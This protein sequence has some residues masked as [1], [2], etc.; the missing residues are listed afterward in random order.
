M[1]QQLV[2]AGVE[3]VAVAFVNAYKN[4]THERRVAELV[5]AQAPGVA[6][7]PSSEVA[8]V[9][10]EYE[11]TS[12]V[13]ADA[14]VLPLADGYLVGMAEALEQRG[15]AGRFYLMLSGGGSA[16][17]ASARRHPIRLVESGPAARASPARRPVP[18]LPA[19]TVSSPATIRSCRLKWAGRRPRCASSTAATRRS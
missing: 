17:V 4:P 12:T 10:R 3:A 9:M 19:S 15:F 1:T 8:P 13:V 5:R 7:S 16:S 14:F 6:V 11:R 2:D 18:R